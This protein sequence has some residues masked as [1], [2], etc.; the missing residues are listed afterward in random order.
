[1]MVLRRCMPTYDRHRRHLEDSVVVALVRSVCQ[2]VVRVNS[3]TPAAK[4]CVHWTVVEDLPP[5]SVSYICCCV[6]ALLSA[7]ENKK[8][9]TIDLI[10]QN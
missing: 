7:V 1:M 8:K 4:V 3:C 10:L 5:T 2:V 6:E 9:Y